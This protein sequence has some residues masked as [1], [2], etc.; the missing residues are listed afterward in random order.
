MKMENG[1]GKRKKG[2]GKSTRQLLNAVTQSTP[3]E[4][5]ELTVQLTEDQGT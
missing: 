3:T 1:N 4:D 2:N 5:R